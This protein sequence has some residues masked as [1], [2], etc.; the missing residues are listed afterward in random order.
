MLLPL[1][2]S[3]G[4][5][6]NAEFFFYFVFLCLGLEGEVFVRLRPRVLER[7]GMHAPHKNTI[8]AYMVRHACSITNNAI[9][10]L[11]LAVVRS[12]AHQGP[13]AR[14]DDVVAWDSGFAHARQRACFHHSPPSTSHPIP[15]TPR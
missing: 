7:L 11:L 9:F 13:I 12:L 5:D 8:G 3:T 1:T 4:K 15:R 6:T 14:V 2:S 10:L